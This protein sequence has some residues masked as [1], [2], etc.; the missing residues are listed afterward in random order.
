MVPDGRTIAFFSSRDGHD[1]LYL[2]N[3]DGSDQRRLP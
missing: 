2:M 1:Q 3:A